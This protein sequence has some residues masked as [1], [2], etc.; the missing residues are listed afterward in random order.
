MGEG[1]ADLI[2]LTTHEGIGSLYCF[3][4][5]PSTH[6]VHCI[7]SPWHIGKICLPCAYFYIILAN[8]FKKVLV[9]SI[10]F[11]YSCWGISGIGPLSFWKTTIAV[12]ITPGLVYTD[13][14]SSSSVMQ[15][16]E[17]II[18]WSVLFICKQQILSVPVAIGMQCPHVHLKYDTRKTG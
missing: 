4:S 16:V 5:F 3:P 10:I 11:T 17:F 7:A 12:V 9:S 8:K 6:A 13:L 1:K 2:S 18:F 15:S 14:N